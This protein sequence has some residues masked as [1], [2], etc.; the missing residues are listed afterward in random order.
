MV[1]RYCFGMMASVST[2]IDLRGAATPSRTVNFSIRRLLTPPGQAN[3]ERV[4]IGSRQKGTEN[5]PP[6]RPRDERGIPIGQGRRPPRT[7][8][9][10]HYE[11][12][13]ALNP[14]HRSAQAP[15]QGIDL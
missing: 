9:R 12:A 2:L 3:C 5:R 10:G 6:R 15:R 14:R 1:L 7:E 11:Q 4:V 8:T 13:V